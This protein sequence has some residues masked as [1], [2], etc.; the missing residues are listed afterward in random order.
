MGES[1][2]TKGCSERLRVTVGMGTCGLAAGAGAVFELLCREVSDRVAGC[3]VVRVGCRGL[4][5]LEPL[6]EVYRADGRHEMYGKVDEETARAIADSVIADEA[7]RRGGSLCDGESGSGDVES[8]LSKHLISDDPFAGQ[9]RRVLSNCGVIDP[10][11]LEEY[12]ATGG[13]ETL[14]R[15]LEGD[16][17]SRIVDEVELSGLRGRGGA[18]FSTGRKWRSFISSAAVASEEAGGA[19]MK[20]FIVNGDEGDPGAYMDRGLLE[21]DPHRVLEGLAL[22]CFA[23]GARKAY[24]FIRA[25][26]ALAVKTVK[27]AVDEAYAAGLL[28]EDILGSGYSLD[29]GVVR[30]AGAFLCGESTAMVNVLEGRACTTRPKPPHMTEKG[31]WGAP[32]CINNVETLAN[33]PL[34]VER[35]AEWF[36]SVGTEESPGTKV[37]SVAGSAENVGLAEVAMGVTLGKIVDDIACAKEPKAVQIGGPSGAILPVGMSDI[38]LTFEGLAHVGGMMGSGGFVVLSQRQCVVETALF[39]TTFSR[40]QSCLKCKLCRD[41]MEEA[42]SI[43]RR[44][45]EGV[46][47]EA[48]LVRLEE[49]A[50]SCAAD[51]SLCGLGRMGLNPMITSLRHFPE[52]YRAHLEKTCP[53]HA[54]RD[55]ISY[56]IDPTKCQGERCCLLSCPGNAIRGPFGKPSRIVE[57]LCQKCGTCVSA[58]CYGAVKTVSPR[59]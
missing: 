15:A 3:S 24:F 45:C 12:R 54:C 18:G 14:V 11:S 10:F 51:K 56:V 55:L 8:V 27:H 6:V 43:L 5:S 46:G 28:G 44:L 57:R 50:L 38:E 21:S 40:A 32:T 2:S 36:R 35:G 39:L 23:T 30:G 37:L 29:V 20:Y 17:A 49:L 22:S 4:C 26:Y 34:I 52:E 41:G 42:A 33:V 16:T 47:E 31:L 1:A 25:E 59:P 48:D 9:T 53:A 58:C 19:P 13:Y 7:S